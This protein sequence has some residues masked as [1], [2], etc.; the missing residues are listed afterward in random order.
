MI[1]WN[2]IEAAGCAVPEDHPVEELVR[3][4]SHALADPD[5]LIRDGAAYSVLSTWIAGGVIDAPRRLAL[6]DEMAA[7][8]LDREIQARTFA[9]LVLDMLVCKGDFRADWV[10]AFERWYPEEEDLRGYDAELGWLHAV[11]HGADLL[12]SFGCHPEVAPAR[13]LDLAAARLT[14]PTVHVWGQLEDDRLAKAVARVLTRSDVSERD[15]TAWLDPVA[16]RF[17]A[18]RTAVPVPAALGNCL[19]TLRMLYV[20]AD[21]GVRTSP[22]AAPVALHHHEA[23]KVRLGEALD[24]I[25]E[26]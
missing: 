11:A 18:D 2:S 10:S 15:A 7:R 19:R 25:V 23:V 21:R 6:G 22:G 26:R 14:A 5:P 13:M 8:F 3:G 12:G 17:A 4:L 9:P 20:F 24:R 1:D 16:A